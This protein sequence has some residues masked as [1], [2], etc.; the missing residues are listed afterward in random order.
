MYSVTQ[1][2]STTVSSDLWVFSRSAERARRRS[3]FDALLSEL[4][5]VVWTQA[6]A[7]TLPWT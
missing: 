4:R 5:R 3:G 1:W 7:V 6:S 2:L